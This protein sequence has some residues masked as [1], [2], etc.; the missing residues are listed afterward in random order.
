VDG[1]LRRIGTL[2]VSI[3]PQQQH[4]AA[5]KVVAAIAFQRLP[6]PIA[7]VVLSRWRGEIVTFVSGDLCGGVEEHQGLL[8]PQG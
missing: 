7:A 2:I 8:P 1:L 3:G 5:S 4:I 6:S